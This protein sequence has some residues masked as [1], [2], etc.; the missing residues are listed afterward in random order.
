MN[1]SPSRSD[2][3]LDAALSR[4]AG[5]FAFLR[6]R[7]LT[8]GVGAELDLVSALGHL[9]VLDAEG[10]RHACRAT[11]AK[12][13]SDLAVLEQAFDAYW[14]SM[15]SETEGAQPP[16]A[17][18]IPPRPP[19]DGAPTDPTPPGQSPE[20]TGAAGIVQV[21]VYSPEAPAPGHPLLPVERRRLA[22][23]RAGARRFRRFAATLPGRRFE[24]SW[25][26]A[27]DFPA[28][29]RRSLRL[30]GE[31]L[32]I[33]H[34]RR[35]RLRS[36]LIVL[37]DVSGSMREHDSDLA[38]LVYSLHRVSRRSRVFAFSMGVGELTPHLA[39]RPY[40]R[41][42][43]SISRVLAPAGGGTQIG[44][45]LEE[46]HHRYGG[47]LRSRTTVLVISDGWDLGSPGV[48][49]REVTW[50]RR[51]AHLVV[52]VNPYARDRGFR[53][54]TAG[55]REVL[56]QVDLLLAPQDFASPAPFQVRGTRP[57]H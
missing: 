25:R 49:A 22:A 4:L 20:S 54:A 50:L 46:F 10:F 3:V 37:W 40:P 30:G 35:K 14:G 34:K 23:L 33:H 17:P 11:L 21:G 12:S 36:E 45:S 41:A 43:E 57:R 47:L 5:F 16:R 51:R 19:A 27:I 44:R 32:D 55:M 2:D 39:A 48:L 8:L 56:P 38:A 26:G 7:G 6:R 29:A 9:G 42:I 15:A 28:T 13:P 1:P 31:W 24:P 53:P 18:E 52:W